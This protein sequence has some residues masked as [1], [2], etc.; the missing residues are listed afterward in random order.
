MFIG[1]SVGAFPDAERT[2]KNF[3][4]LCGAKLFK[5]QND[6]TGVTPLHTWMCV[7][8]NAKMA[9]IQ[10]M[11]QIRF[12]DAKRDATHKITKTPG[13]MFEVRRRGR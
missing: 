9:T 7:N 5:N 10:T 6:F 12:K 1:T 3:G 4:P 11:G 13:G 8:Q 2:G